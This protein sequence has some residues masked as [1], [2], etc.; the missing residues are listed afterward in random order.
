M[1]PK[2]SPLAARLPKKRFLTRAQVARATGRHISTVR[3]WEGRKLHPIVDRDGVRHFD[4]DEV[5]ALA[6]DLGVGSVDT[7]S[8][9]ESE[10]ARLPHAQATEVMRLIVAGESD[11]EVALRT[12]TNPF[13]V[14]EFRRIFARDI[15]KLRRVRSADERDR[16]R[17]EIEEEK[18]AF[19]RRLADANGTEDRS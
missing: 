1:S 5:A 6:A 18:R 17:A 3:R 14:R 4:P 16:R 19:E 2:T 9:S 12:Q 15:D 7:W 8:S 11:R 10:A 13:V